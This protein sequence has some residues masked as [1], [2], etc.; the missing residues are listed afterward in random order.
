VEGA[1]IRKDVLSRY[2]ILPTTTADADRRGVKKAKDRC[3]KAERDEL[4][5][6]A[7]DLAEGQIQTS[8]RL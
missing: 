2:R 4:A 8:S 6:V 7:R 1:K 5:R 3:K